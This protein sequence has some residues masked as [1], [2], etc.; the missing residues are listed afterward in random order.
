MARQVFA[1]VMRIFFEY[2]TYYLSGYTAEDVRNL[3]EAARMPKVDNFTLKIVSTNKEADALEADGLEFRS[4]SRDFDT[5]GALDKGATAFCIFVGRDL[6]SIGWTATTQHAMDS[7]DQPPFKVDFSNNEACTG[8]AWTN[9]KYRRMGLH[10][11]GNLKRRQFL[12]D[13]GITIVRDAITTENFASPK[14]NP[15]YSPRI[16]AEGRYLRVLRW[17]SWKE[18]PLAQG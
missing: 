10:L 4:Y 16:Y 14:T 7:L 17:K 1:F 8:R 5:R 18:R 9:P 3:N 13:K 15:N 12:V 2:Q 6:A 11:Y